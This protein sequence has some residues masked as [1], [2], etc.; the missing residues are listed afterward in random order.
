MDA[1][2]ADVERAERGVDGRRISVLHQDQL[3]GSK[4]IDNSSVH[5]HTAGSAANSH[6]VILSEDRLA[7]SPDTANIAP[8]IEAPFRREIMFADEIQRRKSVE[9]SNSERVPERHSP[10]HHIT[11]VENQRNQKDNTALRIPGP[12]DFER[13]ERPHRVHQEQSKDEHQR[14]ESFRSEGSAIEKFKGSE[15]AGRNKDPGPEETHGLKN[16][17]D[18]LHLPHIRHRRGAS[19][20]DIRARAQSFQSFVSRTFTQNREDNTD[21]LPYLSYAAT[22]G[23]NSEFVDLTEEQREELGGIEYRSLKTLAWVLISYNIG[24]TIFGV[25]VFLPWILRNPK[26]SQIVKDDGQSPVWWGFFTPTSH[27]TDLGFTLTPDSMISFQTSVMPLLV[28]GFLI[29]IGNTGFPCM[30]RLTIWIGYQLTPFG[31]SLWEEFRFL[32]DHPRRCFTLLF[33][34][35]A[36]WWLFIV[37]V[38]LNSID[39]IFFILLDLK[40]TTVTSLPPA[41][42]FLDGLYQAA[43]TRT[44]GLACV[45]LANLH[46]GIQV[47][48]LVM[49][50]ISVFPIAISVRQTNVYEEKSLGIY[51][52]PTQA[53]EEAEGGDDDDLGRSYLG[54]HLR[55]QL[56]FDLWYVFLGLFLICIIEGSRIQDATQ[57]GF[58]VWTV[59]FEIVSAYGTVGL[60][61]GYPGTNASFS[62]QFKP[63]SKLIIIAMMLRGRHRGLP[64]ALD[65]AVLL[66]G[67]GF[68]NDN[69]RR[70]SAANAANP[71]AGVLKE[72][73]VMSDIKEQGSGKGRSSFNLLKLVTGALSAGPVNKAKRG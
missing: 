63:L 16:I 40:D 42:Q 26:Y 58:T 23:R 17:H 57:P 22:I 29:I 51:H 73:G 55:R 56:S 41:F 21:P 47:S 8:H 37:L 34:R 15:A 1:Q 28:G 52:R 62:A 48:Y 64:Y 6:G 68:K 14:R 18:V 72:P 33:P 5:D 3:P 66:P 50:Y 2:V 45:D 67:E 31:N 70:K 46:P 27:F 19:S 20:L 4:T 59:L 69:I 7:N 43:S 36:T 60:S 49:M 25:I 39:L 61:L 44:A 38:L 11:F 54:L 24:W 9:I 13:G 12:M 30:L 32:L 53:E 65:R 10:D 35:R 71:E